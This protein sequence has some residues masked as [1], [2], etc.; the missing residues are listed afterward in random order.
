[1]VPR[2]LILATPG[3][4]RKISQT[5][6]YHAI[7]KSQNC[8]THLVAVC[9]D[10]T[11]LDSFQHI[12]ELEG[13]N[14]PPN[15]HLHPILA[16]QKAEQ[17]SF[18]SRF[19]K[20]FIQLKPT[21]IQ[22]ILAG[23][24]QEV[25]LDSYVQTH[26]L[27]TLEHIKIELVLGDDLDSNYFPDGFTHERW[28]KL[29]QDF[30]KETFEPGCYSLNM[31]DSND[32]SYDLYRLPSSKANRV[33]F[34]VF[35]EMKTIAEGSNEW[36]KFALSLDEHRQLNTSLRLD[37]HMPRKTKNKP[38]RSKKKRVRFPKKPKVKGIVKN[39][40]NMRE[41]KWLQFG[42]PFTLSEEIYEVQ[43]LTHS[44]RF[45]KPL[46]E[47][48]WAH[49]SSPHNPP[50]LASVES[51]T[52][53]IHNLNSISHEDI[54]TDISQNQKTSQIILIRL[55][56]RREFRSLY[57]AMSYAIYLQQSK[58]TAIQLNIL[59]DL[60]FKIP[61]G[62][63]D[64]MLEK[65]PN[66]AY[67]VEIPKNYFNNVEIFWD[68]EGFQG[69]DI[70]PILDKLVL[71]KQSFITFYPNQREWIII[72]EIFNTAIDARVLLHIFFLCFNH[73]FTDWESASKVF[74]G[75]NDVG[76]AGEQKIR[77]NEKETVFKLLKTDEKG[78]D[79]SI[80]ESSY[81]WESDKIGLDFGPQFCELL[82]SLLGH[83]DSTKDIATFTPLMLS[84]DGE[85]ISFK[86]ENDSLYLTEEQ[87]LGQNISNGRTP[88]MFGCKRDSHSNIEL[89]IF[90]A[91]GQFSYM[92]IKKY[93]KFFR[94]D[95][96]NLSKYRIG[97]QGF[98]V[99]V[100]CVQFFGPSANDN[101]P[102]NLDIFLQC[103]DS[104]F[105]L[106]IFDLS[107]PCWIQGVTLKQ[108]KDFL[109]EEVREPEKEE[110][111]FEVW[112]KNNS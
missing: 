68:L 45:S 16:A 108:M 90:D 20:E 77:F 80:N 73:H 100:T 51:P 85:N 96:G 62:F 27:E 11:S 109:F 3:D 58:K 76:K 55:E 35:L 7:H 65:A 22:F 32:Q 53:P 74:F 112:L 106:K 84:F 25:L 40:H 30:V 107:A 12:C 71:N 15:L 1:M 57:K 4:G 94:S 52:I 18:F 75:D 23:G 9:R 14:I 56:T 31:G 39:N 19:E 50:V 102:P 48:Q 46:G 110:W 67:I 64:F 82:L 81:R 34:A 63:Y 91:K 79:F 111:R 13:E 26:N 78:I 10:Q 5:I 92:E 8:E 87:N 43:T 72:H 69:K 88:D 70:L 36:F 104:G 2:N 86:G 93:R 97:L 101:L 29:H 98:P 103:R 6:L 38:K 21:N 49:E 95:I 37:V 89:H 47:H 28:F 60:D 33:G 99:E 105:T 66:T 44:H 54:R 24:C 61:R 17:V 59:I 83:L 41:R 42:N